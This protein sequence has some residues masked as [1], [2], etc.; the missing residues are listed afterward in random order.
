MD[1]RMDQRNGSAFPGAKGTWLVR[2]ANREISLACSSVPMFQRGVSRSHASDL[3]LL[4]LRPVLAGTCQGWCEGVWQKTFLALER[5][6]L[7]LLT[8]DEQLGGRHGH[9]GTEYF[10]LL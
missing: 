2:T 9:G 7:L 4:E 1:P 5:L 3:C 6:C 8:V 10:L